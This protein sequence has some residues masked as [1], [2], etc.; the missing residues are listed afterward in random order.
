MKRFIAL[1]FSLSLLLCTSLSLSS[2]STRLAGTYETSSA[3][4]ALMST[5]YT[6]DGKRVSKSVSL[7][8]SSDSS[9]V[10]EITGKYD[11]DYKGPKTGYEITFIWDATGTYANKT[12]EERTE[13]Y[14]FKKTNTYIKIGDTKYV[15]SNSEGK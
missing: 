3:S 12:E 6:F 10:S 5:S 15:R 4:G 9:W 8:S 14:P 7:F 1:L 11:I 13:T 2:C